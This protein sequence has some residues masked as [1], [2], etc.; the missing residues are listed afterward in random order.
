MQI[1]ERWIIVGFA[2]TTLFAYA[3]RM[4]V[5][6]VHAILKETLRIF[7]SAPLVE[8]TSREDPLT[9]PRTN[10]GNLYL[11]PK[12]QIIMTSLLTHK[13]QDLW[14]PDADDFRPERWFEPALLDKVAK[15]PFMYS[16]FY[17]GPRIV[18]H[19]SYHLF[20]VRRFRCIIQKSVFRTGIRVES[21]WFLHRAALTE[22]PI[23]CTRTGFHARGVVATD[24]LGGNARSTRSR[25][26]SP[27]CQ[28]YDS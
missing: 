24:S 22:I 20:W 23:L 3:D 17:G 2:L 9:I 10:T 11:P 19:P 14:G 18:S 8:R 16:P 1:S 5:Y 27:S 12:T 4:M 21:S 6:T 13:R 28:L 25:K 15:T 26:D 7:P